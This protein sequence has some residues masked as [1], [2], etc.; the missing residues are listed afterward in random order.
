MSFIRFQIGRPRRCDDVAVF[1]GTG[2]FKSF[3]T[4]DLGLFEPG[5]GM[6]MHKCGRTALSFGEKL[7]HVICAGHFQRCQLPSAVR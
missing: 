2:F 3:F 7:T 1:I 5:N 6:L 4:C